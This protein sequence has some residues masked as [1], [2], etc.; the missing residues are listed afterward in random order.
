M[1]KIKL[2]LLTI[3]LANFSYAANDNIVEGMAHKAI[4]GFIN[5]VTGVVEIPVQTYKGFKNGFPLIENQV[6]SKTVGTVLGFFRGGGHAVG[7]TS[8]GIIEL[9]GFWTANRE[10]NQGIGV[11]LDAT[12]AWEWGEQ[13]SFFKPNLAEGVK[14]I[15]RKLIH[16]VSDN[17]LAPLE[18]PG[19]IIRGFQE[20]T[21]VQGIGKGIWFTLSRS[22][23]GFSGILTS[24][25]P[26]PAETYGYAYKSE[27]PWSAL[28]EAIK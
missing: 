15:G 26:N 8:W 16:G 1:K 2:L 23:Y 18:F 28:L 22:H 5:S 4:N 12:Y 20:G 14:P 17:F 27:Y 13:Y 7:R 21:P 24:I 6:A 3:I 25:V 11:P 10:S 9:S 19:Q